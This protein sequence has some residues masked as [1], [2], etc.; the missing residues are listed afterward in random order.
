MG[1]KIHIEELFRTKLGETEIKPSPR[2][3]KGVSRTVRWKQFWRFMPGRV[4]VYYVAG[5]IVT[6]TI[7]TV[8][9][10]GEEADKVDSWQSPADTARIA[11]DSLN[12]S[13]A[14][15]PSD[16]A[17]K[18]VINDPQKANETEESTIDGDISKPS[19]GKKVIEVTNEEQNAPVRE[20]EPV[21]TLVAYFTPSVTE[22]CVPLT[23]EFH[24][25][26]L[27]AVSY[28]WS[29]GGQAEVGNGKSAVVTYDE[30]GTYTVS[31]VA[32]DG[33][34]LARSHTEQIVVHPKPT[35]A[36]EIDAGE[37]YNYTMGAVEYAWLLSSNRK[38]VL[39][40]AFQVDLEQ[41]PARGDSLMLVATN[42]FGCRDTV[43]QPLPAPGTPELQF[44]TAFSPNPNG[45]TGGY[46][47]PNEPGNQVFYPR[48]IEAPIQYSLKIFNKAGELIFET[49]EIGTGWDGYHKE[50]PVPGGV[51][52][53]QCTGT[54]KSG[55]PFIYRGD[56]T[57][58]RN[59]P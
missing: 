26:S 53:Y 48:Y 8:L 11:V 22:G 29:T 27:H 3:W 59:N 13:V 35:A 10:T 50:S 56:V 55:E 40:D 17:S 47:N 18:A 33:Y 30:P 6:G 37:L 12:E 4:N 46:Y 2:V 28:E 36:F 23:V 49:N 21:N 42:I 39:S 5:L 52:I 58:L 41:I 51:Y 32:K 31:L 24:N 20:I 25:A 14:A 9:Y 15:N 43:L 19:T 7:L 54:W 16:T 44:P 1:D 45:A 57:I 38:Q 34:G